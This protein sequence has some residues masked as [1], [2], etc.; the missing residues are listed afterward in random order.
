MHKKKYVEELAE[1]LIG[2]ICIWCPSLCCMQ[3][4]QL[5]AVG[6]VGEDRV[7][8]EFQVHKWKYVNGSKMNF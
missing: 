3:S 6:L 7:L 2:H 5:N 1:E 8:H 4:A